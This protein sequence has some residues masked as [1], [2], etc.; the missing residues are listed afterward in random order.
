[1]IWTCNLFELFKIVQHLGNYDS[2]NDRHL[3]IFV[4]G[5]SHHFLTVLPL[6]LNLFIR[7]FHSFSTKKKQKKR[8]KKTTNQIN[9]I[10]MSI[11]ELIIK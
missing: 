7:H 2:H 1:M 10:I 11:D 5:H 3:I 4:Q 9:L 6:L 8:K